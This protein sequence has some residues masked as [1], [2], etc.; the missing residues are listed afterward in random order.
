LIGLC[1]FQ[2]DKAL[3]GLASSNCA[4][5]AVGHEDLAEILFAGGWRAGDR[6]RPRC[7][8]S[9]PRRSAPASASTKPVGLPAGRSVHK[10]CSVDCG[11]THRRCKAA[12]RFAV[13][14]RSRA[15][16][17][18]QGFLL[19]RGF[20]QDRNSADCVPIIGAPHIGRNRTRITR[21][22]KCALCNRAVTGSR[23][24]LPV[25]R[26]REQLLLFVPRS[27][28]GCRRRSRCS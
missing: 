6:L 20:S 28:F 12:L 14:S 22:R 10:R 16:F 7:G 19:N 3:R 24:V 27:A 25:V 9:E 2:R 15:R 4:R 23:F 5:T 21:S 18:L 11:V 8:I 26:Q 1:T 13:V 17:G